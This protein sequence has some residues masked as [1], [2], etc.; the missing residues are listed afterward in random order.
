VNEYSPGILAQP[1]KGKVQTLEWTT[2]VAYFGFLFHFLYS[3]LQNGV[4]LIKT[5]ALLG[6]FS[7][8]RCCFVP[9]LNVNAD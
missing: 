9:T 5:N 4:I 6:I 2:E 8:K 3:L 7:T 1:R